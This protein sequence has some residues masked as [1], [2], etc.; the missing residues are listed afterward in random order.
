MMARKRYRK[1]PQKEI[2]R[3]RNW[4]RKNPDKQRAIENRRRAR[5]RDAL[6]PGDQWEINA[7][8]ARAKWWRAR[9]FN[10]EVDHI[11]PLGFGWHEPANLQIIS[12]GENI[13]K[14]ANPDYKLK[15]IFV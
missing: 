1:N 3:T 14:H 15:R 12:K 2:L 10:V 11:Y 7:I 4:Q 13:R 8:Y 6:L 9:G 5:K